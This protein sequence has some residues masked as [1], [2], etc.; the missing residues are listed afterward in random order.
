M[1][2]SDNRDIQSMKIEE[3]VERIINFNKCLNDF[4]SNAFEW[5]PLEAAQLLSKSRLDW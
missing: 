2:Y 3:V 5:A 1:I 4:W